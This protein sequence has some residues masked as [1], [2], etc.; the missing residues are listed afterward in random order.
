MR[1]PISRWRVWPYS[2]AC[3]HIYVINPVCPHGEGEDVGFDVLSPVVPVQL[4]YLGVV[5]EADADLRAALKLLGAQHRVAA[6]ADEQA[7]P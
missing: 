5:Q 1:K 7:D 6:A 3:L 2:S 4:P